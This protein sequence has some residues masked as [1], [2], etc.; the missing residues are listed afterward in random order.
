MRRVCVFCGSSPGRD[1]AHA[2]AAR[3]LGTLAARR[4]LGLVYGGGQIGLMGVLADAALAGGGEVVG[5]IPEKLK[6]LELGHTGL[7]RLEV[8]PTMHVRKARMVELSDAFVALPG[9]YGTLDELFEV[10]SWAQL[11]YHTKPVGLLDAAGFFE[12]LLSLLDHQVAAGFLSPRHRALLLVER[13]PA[14]LLDRLAAAC[15]ASSAVS[16]QEP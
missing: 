10:L 15:R 2:E 12:P 11:Q 13:S 3:A 7:T 16:F 6:E 8:V 1:P 14:A 4:G 5:V 9:G